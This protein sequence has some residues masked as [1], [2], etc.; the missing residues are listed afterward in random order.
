[1][2]RACSTN[3]RKRCWCRMR[4]YLLDWGADRVGTSEGSS[5]SKNVQESLI[6]CTIVG[7]SRRK[8]LHEAKMNSYVSARVSA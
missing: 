4:W 1:M 6:G 7:F 8:Q 2:I 3:G 5:G